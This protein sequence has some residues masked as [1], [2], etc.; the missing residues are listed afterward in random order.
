MGTAI[1]CTHLR[2]NVGTQSGPFG[3]VNVYGCACKKVKQA[4]LSQCL[5]CEHYLVRAP[6]PRRPQRGRCRHPDGI[7]T[8]RYQRTVNVADLYKG[9]SCFLVLGGPSLKKLNLDLLRNRGVLIMSVNNCPAGLPEG[10]R[11]HL[12]LHTDP[13]GKMH[14]S[15][16]RDPSIL[17]FAPVNGWQTRYKEGDLKDGVQKKDGIR[18]RKPDNSGFEALEDGIRAIDMPGVLGYE[19]NT[20][21]DLNNWLFEPSIN[22]GNDD[23]HALGEKGHRPNGWPKVINTMFAAVRLAF[24]LGVSRLYLVGAD[25]CMS[26]AEPYAFNQGKGQGGCNGNNNAYAKMATMFTALRPLFDDADFEVINCTP[27]S[28]LWAFDYVPLE[29]AVETVTS[30]FEEVLDARGWYD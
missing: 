6:D 4:T 22:R 7:V 26:H 20:A 1:D 24:Y 17:K 21:F 14:D 28:G 3:S 25:F 12:W 15:I 8:D 5:T 29:E 30:G 10:L 23:Q 16:W 27:A 9:A 13:T 2:A 19:R 11:P 18:K